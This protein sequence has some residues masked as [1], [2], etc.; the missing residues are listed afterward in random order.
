MPTVI[1]HFAN[2]E[3]V[4][5]DIEQLPAMDDTLILV[6]N[7]RRKDGKDLPNLDRNVTQV[8]W[9]LHRITF[10]EIVP[11]GDEEEIIS[12]VRE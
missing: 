1:V 3:A 10:I 8:M 2:D 6:K 5:G 4:M 12:F 9:T 11:T 7:P